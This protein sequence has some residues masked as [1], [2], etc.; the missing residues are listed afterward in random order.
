MTAGSGSR[1]VLLTGASGVIGRAVARELKGHRVIG[2]GHS[3]T[4]VPEVD[5]IL[6]A[7]QSEPFLGLSRERW[8]RLAGEVD[9]IIHSGAL[10]VWGQPRDRYQAINIDGTRRIIDL[11]TAAGAPVHLISTCFVRAIELDAMDL[12]GS[13]NVVKPYI[14]SKLAAERLLGESGVP[15]SI[16][17]PT[18]LVGDTVTGASSRPQ[19]VQTVADWFCRGKAKYY[20]AHPGNLIDVVPLDTTAVAIARAVEADDLGRLYWL[21]VGERAL[22]IEDTQDILIGHARSLGRDVPRVPIVDPREPLPIPLEKIPPTSRNFVKVLIDVSE[23]TAAAGGSLPT[24]LPEL[25]KKY[26]MPPVADR[27]AFRRSLDYWAR[28]RGQ[29]RGHTTT[30]EPI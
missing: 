25:Q 4:D 16:Y 27:E 12:L 24:S 19:I 28:M 10:T 22:T 20:P 17:R 23:V 30:E 1:T 5:E 6:R 2:L 8:D 7:D 29:H 9:V 3:D 14:Q 11:A 18:N 21:T 13:T 26:D 15:H